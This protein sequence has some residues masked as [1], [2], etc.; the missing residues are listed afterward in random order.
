M[1]FIA[2][3][4]VHSK[5]SRATARN[6]DLEHLFM[7]AQLK[8]VTVVGTGDVTHPQ[9]FEEIGQ[10]LEPAEEGLY[11]LKSTYAGPL[12]ERI[13]AACRAPVRFLLS[14][15]ISNI[16]KKEG[17]TRKNH[18]LICLPDLEA[19]AAFNAKLDCIGNIHSDGRPILGLDARD[20]LEILLETSESA[21]LIPA[22][23]WTPWFSLLGSKSGFE[24]LEECFQDLAPHIFAVET[25][26]S[27]DPPMNW[28]VSNLDGLTLVSNSDAHSPAKIGREANLFD[29]Q[30]SY[31]AIR[32]ALET[33]NPKQF[34]GTIEFY[35]Q[36]GK[37]HLDGHRKCGVINWPHQSLNQNKRCPRCG[38]A[39]TLGVLHRV[40]ELADRPVG[41]KPQQVHPFYSLVP[42]NEILSEISGVGPATKTV[43]SLMDRA[44]ATLGP[45]LTILR[46]LPLEMI[47][48][49]GIPLLAEAVGRMRAGKINVEPGFD[50][51]YGKVKLFDPGERVRLRGQ[52]SLFRAN[53]LKPDK[54]QIRKTK[55]NKQGAKRSSLKPEH[56]H[57]RLKRN[58]AIV[59]S[60]DDNSASAA[61]PPTLN[62][63]QQTAVD[64]E[65]GPLLIVA[66]PG[67]GK[68]LTI[69]LRIS[70]LI[71]SRGCDPKR[72]L[73]VTFTNKA[74]DEMQ[75]RL[76]SILG[77]RQTVPTVATFHGL[78]ARILY[79]RD[80][81]GNIQVIDDVE[82]KAM[83]SLA[84]EMV[85]TGGDRPLSTKD[86]LDA[87]VNAKQQQLTPRDISNQG[88]KPAL[89]RVY[90][91]YQRLLDIE[92]R[93]DFEDI[94]FQVVRL[95]ETDK[96]ACRRYQ[97]RYQWIFIDEYQDL[98][99][100]QYRL[101]Q[102]LA[103]PG[104]S[105]RQICAIGDPNQSIYGFR[106][107]DAR[108]FKCFVD[109]YPGTT[110][111]RLNRNYRS[112]A[113][114]LS[115][116]NQVISRGLPQG[117]IFEKPLEVSSSR[118]K[119]PS[120]A[121]ENPVIYI[122]DTPNETQEVKTIADIIEKKVGGTGFHSFDT[123][124]IK[125]HGSDEG[126]GY[127][128]FAIL[129]RTKLQQRMF[130]DAF[131]K[132]G[133]PFQTVSRETFLD[134]PGRAELIS[135]LKMVHGCASYADF[136]R[137][138]PVIGKG[139]GKTTIERVRRWGVTRGFGLNETLFNARRFP[140]DTLGAR[141]QRRL[142]EMI[143]SIEQIKEKIGEL[144][145]KDQVTYIKE[146]TPLGGLIG[147]NMPDDQLFP[148]GMTADDRKQL[149]R[150]RRPMNIWHDLAL[151][152]DTD[153]YDRRAQKAALMSMHAA[154][155]LE[156]SVVF[157]VGCEEGLIPLK[158]PGDEQCDMDEER[159]LF[160]V[161]MTRA[162]EQLYLSYA[163]SRQTYGKRVSRTV[164]PFVASIEKQLIEIRRSE[165]TRRKPQC[166][167]MQLF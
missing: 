156:F 68:T 66:G 136:F 2:D 144:A 55:K 161:A 17:K 116:S 132:R 98:N 34:L 99:A 94:I 83:V 42:L 131:S 113:T 133:I 46:Q 155:G 149:H 138:T 18:N 38:K 122:L 29:T 111:I 109:D 5:Y 51:E 27:S 77:S 31:G 45:E 123:G 71:G 44:Q 48:T 86:A 142:N 47:E 107:S 97:Q 157:I 105:G 9:W 70:K 78:C 110:V 115:A 148:P 3:I 14:V 73:A 112:T 163:R 7:A 21:F 62:T 162:R 119:T 61:P 108:F 11:R 96:Q 159:R 40:E 41:E 139:V 15:E 137:L 37:Y 89:G 160:Y 91:A 158:R 129:Y 127:S 167:Q 120:T 59:K 145:F 58:T 118:I 124:R 117:G 60:G 146:K 26:L 63:R 16:Y 87:I 25:G 134:R 130:A 154:K 88:D 84:L 102:L 52:A 65:V 141:A 92:N 106:G 10:K 166:D 103:P 6:L 140:I 49:A 125:Q 114:I 152:S 22:H 69:T 101:V 153:F 8:G 43:Q 54:K 164:S 12:R 150:D 135:L 1:H 76:K 85:E 57:G 19:A 74:A 35:P 93:C 80:P 23:I 39:L 128:D 67:T 13:P 151:G 126:R 20:L 100:G 104:Q 81:R 95:L 30:L 56:R 33:G 165:K 4:H 32:S 72:I 79:E 147:A 82:R 121:P 53:L 24:T 28:R 64:H 143:S 90:A 36:E 75:L 50:G